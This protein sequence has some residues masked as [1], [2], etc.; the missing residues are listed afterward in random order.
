M[1]K[2]YPTRYITELSYAERNVEGALGKAKSDYN[3]TGKLK[4]D[5]PKL[6]RKNIFYNTYALHYE[7]YS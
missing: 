6:E 2:S 7:I 4:S 5:C 3:V 1:S